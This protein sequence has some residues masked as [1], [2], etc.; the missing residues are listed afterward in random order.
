MA[1]NALTAVGVTQLTSSLSTLYTVPT[2]KTFTVAVIHLANTSTSS[3]N[4][5]IC[6][7]TGSAAQANALLW[8]FQVAANDCVEVLKG[9]IWSSG[10]ILSGYCLP[11]TTVNIKLSGIETTP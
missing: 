5:R 1:T 2:G 8:D 11:T 10:M 7:T 6:L 3:A 4:V 9:D